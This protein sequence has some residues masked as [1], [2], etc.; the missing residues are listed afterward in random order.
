MTDTTIDPLQAPRGHDDRAENARVIAL[1][2][3]AHGVSHFFHL[4][5][6]PIFPWLRDAFDLSY[7][8][9]GLLLTVMFTVSG[10]GQ[11]LAGFLVDRVGPGPVM[12]GALAFFAAG[13]IVFGLAPSW[14]WL[15]VGAILIGLGNAPFHPVDYS[16]L[17]ARIATP[18]LGHAYAMH[19]V[20]GSLGWALAPVFMVGLAQAFSWR[21]AAFGAGLLAAGMLVATWWRRDLLAIDRQ[22]IAAKAA[23]ASSTGQFAFLRLP[24]VW[25]SFGFFFTLAFAFGGVQSFGP[26]S[27]RLIHDVPLGTVALC[28]TAYMLASAGGMLA[29]GFVASD[30]ARAER[31]IALCF[32]VAAAIALTLPFLPW[33]GA[34]MPIPFALMG[35]AGGIA[36][37]S[38]DLL[39]RRA[40]P[41][42]ATGRVYGVVYS[43]LDLGMSIAPP[44][45]GLMLDLGSPAGVWIGIA[46][47]Q[48]VMI[49]VAFRAGT[50]ASR[51]A[52][53]RVA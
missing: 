32:S 37:P 19:G 48:L 28:L 4:V 13:G 7:A 49:G 10:V 9:L 6:P 29:G 26:E 27:A 14:E 39:I 3:S 25:L 41:P 18:R 53:A 23:A 1:V 20:A 31:T 21:E 15:V 47:A 40:S 30:P 8:Q 11:A 50:E 24:A 22:A 38:R 5:L 12:H 34:A 46:L 52:A 17:N 36:N 44:L 42:G 51:Q 45:F 16:I 33:P 43:G 2:S 35:L